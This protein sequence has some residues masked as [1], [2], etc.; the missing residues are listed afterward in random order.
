MN[1]QLG[2]MDFSNLTSHLVELVYTT[3]VESKYCH[4]VHE[5][6]CSN[7][8]SQSPVFQISL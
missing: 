7:E 4:V 2:P 8:V 5:D 6:T 1:A 3:V